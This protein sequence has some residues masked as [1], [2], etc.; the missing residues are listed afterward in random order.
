MMLGASP[1]KTTRKAGEEL[2]GSEMIGQ[3]VTSVRSSSVAFQIP[4]LSCGAGLKR[5]WT[6]GWA[7]TL[8]ELVDVEA[9]FTGML[10]DAS[11][12]LS[13]WIGRRRI[14]GRA[15]EDHGLLVK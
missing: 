1:E 2:I 10:F 13:F 9:L 6:R 11:T 14:L 5:R 7:V 3:A 12:W 4:R 8:A 15:F